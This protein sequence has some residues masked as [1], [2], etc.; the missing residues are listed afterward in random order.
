MRLVRIERRKSQEA[1]TASA[2]ER[3]AAECLSC[4]ACCAYYAARPMLLPCRRGALTG[5][6][7]YTF[8]A[9]AATRY[10]WPDGTIRV[11]REVTYWLRRRRVDG[12]WRCAALAGKLGESVSCRVY[13]KRPPSCRQFEPGSEMCRET[14]RWAGLDP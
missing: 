10:V 2:R 13:R 14:R 5:D 7:A 6:P 4:G 11:L 1:A 3:Y 9:R 12:R 8:R